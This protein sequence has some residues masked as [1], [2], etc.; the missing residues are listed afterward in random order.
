MDFGYAFGYAFKDPD[1]FKKLAIMG[2]VTLI[3]VLGQFVLIGWMMALMRRVINRQEPA[4]LPDLDFSAQL[5]DGFKAFVVGIVYQAPA[6]VI[7]ILYAIVAAIGTAIA[8]TAEGDAINVILTIITVLGGCTVV[9]VILYS[10]FASLL[11]P[12]AYSKVATEG[13]IKA[14]LQFKEVI[15]TVKASIGSYLLALLGTILATAIIAPLGSIACGLGVLLTV[16]FAMTVNAA[17]YGMAYN[18]AQG[19]R[20]LSAPLPPVDTNLNTL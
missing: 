3:P 12:A 15:A 14:G 17:L 20:G 4:L 19:N 7:Y 11:I 5:S 16:P 1:W 9:L 6:L 8:G 13:T 2:L 10:L 18:V